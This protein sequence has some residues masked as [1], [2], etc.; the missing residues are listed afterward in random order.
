MSVLLGWLCALNFV[1]A[2]VVGLSMLGCILALGGARLRADWQPAFIAA[3][4]VALI[5]PIFYLPVLFGIDHIYAW[6]SDPSFAAQRWYL[7]P[8]F[9]IVRAVACLIAWIVASRYA[10]VESGSRRANASALLVLFVSANVMA[11]DWDMALTS[12]WHS[13]VFGLRWC[14]GGLLCAAAVIAIWQSRGIT[15]QADAIRRFDTANLLFA[16][17][18]G[19]LYLFFVDYITA[20]SGNLPDEA[21]WFGVRM[22]GHAGI[23]AGAM[24]SLHIAVGAALLFRRVKQSTNLLVLLGCGL[25]VAQWIGVVWTIVPASQGDHVWSSAFAL[26]ATIACAAIAYVWAIWLPGRVQAKLTHE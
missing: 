12:Q 24:I 6:S 25:L 21:T 16:I 5:L 26:I 10:A 13:S 15:T 9:A 20:W 17:D 1:A 3:A 19:W 14:V 22:S 7:N 18:L 2:T 8:T 4:R 23:V 11:I